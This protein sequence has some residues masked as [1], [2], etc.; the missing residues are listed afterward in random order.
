MRER[1]GIFAADRVEVPAL[2][3]RRGGKK[4]LVASHGITS[5][6]TE[7]GLYERFVE[8]MPLDYDALLFDFRGHGDS[9][10]DSMEVTIAGEL[11]D[12][13]AVFHWAQK[14]GYSAIDHVAT[15]FGASITLLAASAYGLPFL[16]KVAFWNPVVSYRNTFIAATV[17]WGKTFFD[18]AAIGDLADRP[19]TRISESQFY[20][21]ARMTQELLLLHPENV[22]WPSSVPLLILHGSNDTAVPVSDSTEY[23]SRNKAH[24]NILEGVDHG[25]DAKAQEAIQLTLAWL[26][27]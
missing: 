3:F 22:E 5:E 14:K 18:Q 10:L 6:K 21:S 24:I 23:A 16:R 25:F 8:Q 12:L 26:R 19:Y 4:L 9:S 27:E 15:S 20:I 11:L 2:H 17:E 13:M 1:F 7:E